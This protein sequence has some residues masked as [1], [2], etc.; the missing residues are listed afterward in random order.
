MATSRR[1]RPS[2]VWRITLRLV[3]ASQI[4]IILTIAA[5]CVQWWDLTIAAAVIALMVMI[6]AALPIAAAANF[7]ARGIR[8]L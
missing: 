1:K 3:I 5:A 8:K 4:S 7:E 2:F 6:A